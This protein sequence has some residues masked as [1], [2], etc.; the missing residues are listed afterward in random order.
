LLAAVELLQ[1]VDQPHHTAMD[2]ILEKDMAGQTLVNAACNVTHLR[3][4]FHQQAFALIVV[5]PWGTS[6]WVRFGHDFSVPNRV[7][8]SPSIF[9]SM[10][11]GWSRSRIRRFNAGELRSR[12]V[13][14]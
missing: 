11:E 8:M 10:V 9:V 2:H 1:G 7:A 4:L 5:L 3:Q 14:D 13:G 6:A 12:L